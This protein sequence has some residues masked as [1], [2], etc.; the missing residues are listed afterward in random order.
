MAALTAIG[1]ASS[2]DVR[3]SA[4]QDAGRGRRQQHGQQPQQRR[5]DDPA[6]DDDGHHRG[7]REASAW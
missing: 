3:S 1:S 7:H 4:G 2:A 6:E 5:T